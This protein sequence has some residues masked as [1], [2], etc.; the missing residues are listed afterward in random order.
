MG[1]I[2]RGV[3]NAFRNMVRTFSIVL[4][5]AMSI[6]MSLIMLMSLK[7]VQSKI[8][9]V[10]STI[11]N[12]ITISPAGV[13]GFEG[14]GDLLT[15]QNARDAAAISD[16]SS[17]TRTL[18]D[19]LRKEGTV[20]QTRPGE[21]V[22]AT[23]VNNT[24]NL[25]SSIDPG[26][27]GNRQRASDNGGSAPT[28]TFTMP[29]TLTGVS[30]L[31]SVAGLSALGVSQFNVTSGDKID[32]NSTENIAM[33]GTSLA[34]K[35]NLA[36]GSTFQAYGQ[37]I[38]VKGIFD[39][40]NDF[41][42]ATIVMPIQSVQTLSAQ[43]GAINQL[44]I[45][46]D[47]IDNVSSVESAVKTKLGDKVDVTSQ[48]DSSSEAVTPLRNIKTISL[49][50]LIG[51]LVAGTII[52]FLTMVMIVRERRREIGVLKAIGAS[53]ASVVSQFTVEALVLTITSSVLGVILGTFLSNPILKVLVNNS[54]SSTQ[55]ADVAGGR[56]PQGM[57]RIG[58]N[59]SAGAQNAVRDLH[60]VI[61][62]EIL[63]YGLFAAVIIAII[64]SALPAYFIAKI[65]PAEVM[66]TE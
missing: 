59:F 15:D 2:K 18:S 28:G 37:A 60:A 50:S 62:W 13:R 43:A 52:I 26:S 36:V 17:V 29:I 5:L 22:A 23:T 54:E 31:N 48:Q 47:S 24:T 53:N 56:G 27:F 51:S 34:T 21:T 57:M 32:G 40:G 35:N 20:A 16:V 11:G 9:S 33:V 41:A 61:G 7:T 38:T 63:L 6:A 55:T 25:D 1:V 14:G 19:R 12:V 10:K 4:I 65:R 39:A 49:Y 45:T 66:R 44:I 8:D 58:V 42:N 3:K 30:D 46:T 64:G